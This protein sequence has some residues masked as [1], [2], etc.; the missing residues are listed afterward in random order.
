MAKD[1]KFDIEA[2]EALKT[3]V[4]KLANAVKTTLGPQG[5]NVLIES[6]YGDAHIT[7]DGVSVARQIQLQD[8]VENLGAN[9]VK[10]VASKTNDKAGDGTTTAT[11]LAQAIVREGVK[12]IAAGAN[13]MDLKRGIDTASKIVISNLDSIT[14]DVENDSAE[15]AQVASI[16]ANND[17][18]IGQMIADAY[19]KVGR[20][21]K[22]SIEQSNTSETYIK[23][24]EG[25][26]FDRGYISPYFATNKRGQCQ[27]ENVSILL[28]KG[29]ISNIKDIL[30]IL[31]M[32]L[33]KEKSLLIIAD[34]VEGEALQSL[35]VNKMEA[36]V[37]VCA[38]KSPGYGERRVAYL[39]DMAALTGGKVVSSEK[40]NALKR[41]TEE[42]LGNCDSIT[43]D[44][45]TT[46]IVGGQGGQ[47][48]V[49][50]RI[51]ELEAQ[52]EHAEN[53]YELGKLEERIAKL[54]GGVGAIYVG[55]SSEVEMKEKRDRIEDALNATK[56]AL[57]EGIVAGGGIALV[58]A[59]NVIEHIVTN[60]PDELIGAKILLTAMEAPLRQIAENAGYE[61]SVVLNKVI[62]A[63]SD[64]FGFNAKTG[65]YVDDMYK[66]GI[67]D[68]KKV[69]RI[70][71]EN[72]ASVA[73]M[74]LT[75]EVT[76]T[77]IK[78][79]KD[80]TKSLPNF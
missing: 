44:P 33:G 20:D 57:E 74:I 37:K 69:T 62:E 3:G 8:P 27:L 78:E 4:D 16:S 42:M 9:M 38:V 45:N 24:V 60:T 59:T 46:T 47:E 7:K 58:Q 18:E 23:I 28:Y 80:P 6:H 54:K 73:G 72:A 35:V 79:D 12:N 71:L 70:A 75:T 15:I 11:V 63:N 39:E 17:Q 19:G 61:G 31:E 56:A 14:R 1:I 48:F 34:N 49:N 32:T 64:T 10:S 68:P 43:V 76:L 13:P 40:G 52:K 51:E 2:R 67:I 22:I 41:V 5:R 26:E 21:G 66:S 36:N 77:E 30:N 55:A 25:M 65:E 53:D 29:T 50:F